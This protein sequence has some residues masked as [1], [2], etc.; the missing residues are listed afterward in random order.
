MKLIAMILF[1][2]IPSIIFAQS[3]YH[4]GYIVKS[5]GDTVK[6]YIDYREWAI[7]PLNVD[8]KINLSEKEPQQI[9]AANSR[10]FGVDGMETYISYTGPISMDRNRFPDI[11]D[12]LDTTEARASIFIKPLITGKYISLYTQYDNQKTRY[13]TTEANTTPVELKYNYYFNEK[14]E[15]VERA[16]FRGQLIIYADKYAPGNQALIEQANVTPFDEP[17]LKDIIYKI[18]GDTTP[19][20]KG[21]LNTNPLRWFI[22]AGYSHIKNKSGY[23]GTNNTGYIDHANEPRIS[24]GFDHF[25]NPNVQQWIFRTTFSFSYAD[26]NALFSDGIQSFNQFNVSVEAQILYNLYNKDNFKYYIGLGV[27]A[28][29]SS[30][31]SQS[32]SGPQ[33]STAWFNI[34]F[35]TGITI[36]KQWDVSFIFSPYTKISPNSY[37]AWANQSFGI[38]IKTFLDKY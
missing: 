38:G 20:A 9:S 29:H 8:F 4:K 6:G 3:N 19:R 28:Y 15:A 24:F 32:N 16:F 34:P 37:N 17:E 36:N 13:F 30:S 2:G 27:G 7:T 1:L 5:N 33:F 26:G 31:S 10:G 22:G 23:Y 14:H 18:N 11:A 12:R 25:N 35:Q 21:Q